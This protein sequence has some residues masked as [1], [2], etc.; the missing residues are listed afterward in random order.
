LL[1]ALGVAPIVTAACSD[2]PTGPRTIEVD[3]F[4][5]SIRHLFLHLEP[6]V[7]NLFPLFEVRAPVDVTLEELA[8]AGSLVVDIPGG[9]TMHADPSF[10]GP[11]ERATMNFQGDAIT[12][13]LPSG[14]YIGQLGFRE[15]GD[16]WRFEVEVES[17]PLP[18]AV[19]RTSTTTPDTFALT[20]T[21]PAAPHRWRFELYSRTEEGG[22][23]TRELV[24]TSES[25]E[26]DGTT[27]EIEGSVSLEDIEV[28]QDFVAYLILT[29]PMTEHVYELLETRPEG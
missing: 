23:E 16:R 24:L 2:D 4:E 18:G 15:L 1:L 26:L 7:T 22:V 3:G 14:T 6:G 27:T 13:P 20:W 19:L 12:D 9:G 5:L 28:G 17:D 21:A 10:D 11:D 8:D 25:T 29:D